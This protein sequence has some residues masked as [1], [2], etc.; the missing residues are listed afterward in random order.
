MRRQHHS[1]PTV[2][3]IVER[4]LANYP[5]LIPAQPAPEERPQPK[6]VGAAAGKR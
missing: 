5:G 4:V 1:E 3:D 2:E 6:S